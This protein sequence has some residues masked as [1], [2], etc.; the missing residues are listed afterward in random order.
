MEEGIL[1]SN[2][3]EQTVFRY[4][5]LYTKE[6]LEYCIQCLIEKKNRRCAKMLQPDYI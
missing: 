6:V 2:R 4:G 1:M 5:V 3:N